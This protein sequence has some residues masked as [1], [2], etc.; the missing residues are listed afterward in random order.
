MI[1]PFSSFSSSKSS[2][3]FS[4]NYYPVV[5]MYSL[6][7]EFACS[8]VTI[9]AFF[10]I[11]MAVSRLSP[12]HI[13]TLIPA[14]LHYIIASLIPFLSGSQIPQI[15]T[16]VRSASSTSL[17]ETSLKSLLS[18]LICSNSS[19]ENF[20]YAIKIVLN[21]CFAKVSTVLS[22]IYYPVSP[23]PISSEHGTSSSMP[24]T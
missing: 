16:A 8:S 4:L 20:L 3:T 5:H 17:S 15:P 12:V 9:P 19:C 1:L 18:A 21:A 13:M 2:P 14:S 23:V 11:A 22:I 7:S 6:S 24:Y 10:E